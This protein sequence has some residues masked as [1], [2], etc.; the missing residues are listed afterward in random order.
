MRHARKYYREEG[1]TMVFDAALYAREH[2][3]SLSRDGLTFNEEIA[4][5]IRRSTYEMGY[6]NCGRIDW[7][8][9]KRGVKPAMRP[10]AWRI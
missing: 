6:G 8:G 3:N 2:P 5:S 4:E 7:Q 10:L 1:N 9:P